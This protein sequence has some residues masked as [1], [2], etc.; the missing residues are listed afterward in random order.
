MGCGGSSA[1][2]AAADYLDLDLL[3]PLKPFLFFCGEQMMA[4]LL[5]SQEAPAEVLNE[6]TGGL[7]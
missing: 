3:F 1:A 7:F 4:S 2:A 6:G 5:G